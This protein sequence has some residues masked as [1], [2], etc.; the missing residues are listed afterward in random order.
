MTSCGSR[1]NPRCSCN[2]WLPSA[3]CIAERPVTAIVRAVPGTPHAD[4][5]PCGPG[6]GR[7]RSAPGANRARTAVARCQRSETTETQLCKRQHFPSTRRCFFRSNIWDPSLRKA[8]S[9]LDTPTDP[10]QFFYVYILQSESKPG[11]FYTG[12]SED[13]KQRLQHHTD[14]CCDYTRAK[15]RAAGTLLP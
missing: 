15:G 4:R 3:A 7:R 10:M 2:P 5:H 12:F 6:C 8:K 11:R 1:R 13:L 14:G 9:N